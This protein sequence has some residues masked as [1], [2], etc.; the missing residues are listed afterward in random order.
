MRRPLIASSGPLGRAVIRVL[1][2]A[3][4]LAAWARGEGFCDLRPSSWHVTVIYS[5]QSLTTL[6]SE[7]LHIEPGPHR[8]V[9]RMGGLITLCFRSP[10]LKARHLV[11]RQAGGMW[12]FPAYRPHVSF[13][14]DDGRNLQDIRPFDGMLAFGP[15]IIE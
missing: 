13:T 10:A 15:E 8:Q 1:D 5:A 9:E 7:P 11:H 3:V 2:N 12:D 6:D 14:P 4:T